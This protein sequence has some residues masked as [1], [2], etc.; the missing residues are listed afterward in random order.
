M[1][2][3]SGVYKCPWCKEVPLEDEAVEDRLNSDTLGSCPKC[4]RFSYCSGISAKFMPNWSA[5]K[6]FYGTMKMKE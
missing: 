1:S 3:Y 2:T 6:G 5:W 4:G